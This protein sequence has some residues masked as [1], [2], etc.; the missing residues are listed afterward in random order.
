MAGP[1]WVAL[2]RVTHL[3]GGVFEMGGGGGMVL[4]SY[5]ELMPPHVDDAQLRQ[6]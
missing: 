3:G 2:R 5:L 6:Q 4:M 1:P